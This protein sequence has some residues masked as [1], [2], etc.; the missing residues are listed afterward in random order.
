VGC[1]LWCRHTSN[2]YYILL[3]KEAGFHL[4][5]SL[6]GSSLRLQSSGSRKLWLIAHL[7]IVFCSKAILANIHTWTR[8]QLCHF[9]GSEALE[10]LTWLY[11]SCQ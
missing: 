7:Y 10:S 6:Q 5:R 2:V 8:G 3:S 4:V 11:S 9:H 1:V